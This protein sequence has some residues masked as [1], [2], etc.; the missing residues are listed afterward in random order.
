M[1]SIGDVKARGVQ[2]GARFHP[3]T[4]ALAKIAFPR[5]GESSWILR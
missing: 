4:V 3:Y 2:T 5:N 1:R